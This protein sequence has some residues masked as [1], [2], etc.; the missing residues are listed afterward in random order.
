MDKVKALYRQP[1]LESYDVLEFKDGR[2]FERY[3]KPQRIG[4]EIGGRV[5][6]FR[7]VTE[8]RRAERELQTSEE[9]YR[10]L[11]QNSNDAIFVAQDGVI[12]FPNFKTEKF[13]GYSAAE[14][15]VTPFVHHIHPDDRAMVVKTI[16]ALGRQNLQHLLFRARIR[17][18]EDL[19]A[20]NATSA[21]FGRENRRPSIS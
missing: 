7:D 14:L 2:V 5:W 4:E 13:L 21:S 15:A 19:W 10:L 12:K 9:K 17:R 6:S 11:I 20:I 16:K 3:S 18:G 8:R 1:D